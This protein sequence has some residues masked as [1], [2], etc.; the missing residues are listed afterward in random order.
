VRVTNGRWLAWA[1]IRL[2]TKMRQR[3]SRPRP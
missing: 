2:S 1:A 3:A